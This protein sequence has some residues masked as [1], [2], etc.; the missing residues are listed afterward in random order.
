[1]KVLSQTS[2]LMIVALVPAACRGLL[3]HLCRGA[4]AIICTPSNDVVDDLGLPS[5]QRSPD[6]CMPS[7]GRM[8]KVL[9]Y[10][11]F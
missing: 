4:G 10:C 7:S 3:I 8:H 1:M 5:R 9:S 11:C 2:A 6:S